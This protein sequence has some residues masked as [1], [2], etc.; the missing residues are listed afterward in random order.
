MAP[1]AFV[2]G[3]RFAGDEELDAS[4]STDYLVVGAGASGLAFVDALAA[5]ADVD[6]IVVDKRPA[7]ASHSNTSR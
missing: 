4:V 7:P 5:E 1:P 3:E 6:V 2:T